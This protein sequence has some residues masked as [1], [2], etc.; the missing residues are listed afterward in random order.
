MLSNNAEM[1]AMIYDIHGLTHMT[2]RTTVLSNNAEMHAMI[3]DIHA[4]THT[5]DTEDHRAVKQ[6]QDACDD[7]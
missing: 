6:R 5:H 3:Y 4:W 7:I 1:H 2:Q